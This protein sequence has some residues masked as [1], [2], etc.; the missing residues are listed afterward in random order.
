MSQFDIRKPIVGLPEQNPEP[1][2]PDDEL[3]WTDEE[4]EK[5]ERWK[6]QYP[7]NEAAIMHVL[8]L[9]QEKY[10]WLPPE[11]IE[12]CAD[13]LDMDYAQ[14]YGVATF[15]TQYYKEEQGQFV[16]D[17]CTCFSCQMVGGYDILHYLEEKLGIH[18]GETTE[19][20]MFTVK[21][22]E[23]LGCCG[24]APMMQVANGPYVHNLTKEKVDRLLE[25]LRQGQMP[26]FTSITLPQDEDEMGGNRRTDIDDDQIETY[27]TPPRSE[28]TE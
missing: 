17:V 18:D 19:D 2:V 6:S 16:L 23:C 1:Q 27:Q 13:T 28:A 21:E 25:N 5:I 9:A 8:W 14:A 20:G 15:Y 3:V 4:K 22:V 12:F 10:D 24:S 7:T 11:V 26:K